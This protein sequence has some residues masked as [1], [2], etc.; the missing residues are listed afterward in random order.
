MYRNFGE[1]FKKYKHHRIVLYG[2]GIISAHVID[3]NKQF[4]IV[5]IL[6]RNPDNI[7]KMYHGIK[8]ENIEWVRKNSDI[9]IICAAKDNWETIY[10]RL[11][12]EKLDIFYL[13]GEKA[14]IS[15]KSGLENACLNFGEIERL[16]DC[17]DIISFDMFDTLV[18]RYFMSPADVWDYEDETCSIMNQFGQ[19]RKTTEYEIALEFKNKA[20]HI[21]DIYGRINKT[22]NDISALKA[23]EINEELKISLPIRPIIDLFKYC[24]G[25]EKEVY[26]ASD[27]YLPSDVLLKLLAKSGI[28]DFNK[29]NIIVSSEL[30]MYKFTG[31]MW[32]W[33]KDNIVKEREALHIGDNKK[34]DYD[35]PQKY[36]FSTIW[37][38]NIYDRFCNSIFGRLNDFC[39]NYL[40]SIILK[41]IAYR[42][43][44]NPFV[45]KQLSMYDIGFCGFGPI[46]FICNEKTENIL[47]QLSKID[48]WISQ[49]SDFQLIVGGVNDFI[50]IIK[51]RT[52]GID[53]SKIYTVTN[54]EFVYKI[55]D[56]IMKKFYH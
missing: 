5:G 16:I 11:H 54:R 37:I 3:Y 56:E 10:H 6:D 20:V 17:H 15:R 2:T 42:L 30:K 40:Q 50:S 31:S 47:G 23:Y 35:I 19:N 21:D 45:E 24:V 26:I 51:E 18:T 25:K 39:V 29:A 13:S 33:F 9:V 4:N 43:C 48:V 14:Y 28:E 27:M 22:S 32:R 38:P 55:K 44:E 36:G 1:I 53:E 49:Y 41:T 8:I 52:V 12:D 34:S 7:G 46:S